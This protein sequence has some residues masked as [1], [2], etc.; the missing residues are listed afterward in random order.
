MRISWTHQALDRLDRTF[1]TPIRS[2]EDIH[3]AGGGMDS[4]VDNTNAAG[5][6]A[7]ELSRQDD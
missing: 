5:E 4:I 2:G 1:I 6:A 7:G 3:A